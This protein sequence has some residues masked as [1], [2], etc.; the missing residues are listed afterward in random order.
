MN[1][2][3]D[4][5][6]NAIPSARFNHR[7]VQQAMS[8]IERF[9]KEKTQMAMVTRQPLDSPYNMGITDS[10][11]TFYKSYPIL[12]TAQQLIRRNTINDPIRAISFLLL[13]VSLDI[14]YNII[15]GLARGSYDLEKIYA[16]AKKAQYNEAARKALYKMFIEV[17]VR[18]PLFTTSIPSS[19]ISNV[20]AAAVNKSLANSSLSAVE[21]AAAMATLLDMVKVCQTFLK[22]ENTWKDGVLDM[23][24]KFG[25]VLPGGLGGP[26]TRAAVAWAYNSSLGKSS[27]EDVESEI[28]AI[29]E[30]HDAADLETTTSKKLI[31]EAF[32]V[33]PNTTTVPENERQKAKT[34]ELNDIFQKKY[35]KKLEQYKPKEKLE[36]P[37]IPNITEQPQITMDTKPTKTLENVATNPEKAPKELL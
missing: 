8:A 18:H 22:P 23:Y 2:Y 33:D 25:G 34:K 16:Q 13:N 1:V 30:A 15:L 37:E 5:V 20:T 29:L 17:G 14:I 3:N 24:R 31:R 10:L 36:K 6:S 19:I 27:A 4:V 28:R 35:G 26:L 9:S 32:P 21:E 7:D 11:M 12:F